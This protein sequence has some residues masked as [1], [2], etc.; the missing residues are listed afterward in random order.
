VVAAERIREQPFQVTLVHHNDVIQQVQSAAFNPTLR[1][2]ILPRALEQS[3]D[4]LDFHRSDRDRDLH[5][6][7][8]IAIEDDEPGSR[9]K[10]IR[11]SQ[12]L[13]D[14]SAGHVS[15]HQVVCFLASEWEACTTATMEQRK[16]LTA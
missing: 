8:G 1:N 3:A 2:S 4:T 11:F 9:P 5:P 16:R 13:N 14:P 10:R 15:W 12:L 7:L 6:I